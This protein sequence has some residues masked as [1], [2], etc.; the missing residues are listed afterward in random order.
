MEKIHFVTQPA[1]SYQPHTL[2][3]ALANFEKSY[4][5]NGA[6]YGQSAE[7]EAVFV[8]FNSGAAYGHNSVGNR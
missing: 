5:G 2:T 1:T 7:I 6:F 4:D 8:R 3:T